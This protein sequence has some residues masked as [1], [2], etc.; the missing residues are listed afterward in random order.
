MLSRR[1]VLS[2]SAGLSCFKNV[3]TEIRKVSSTARQ[4]YADTLILEFGKL[5]K[6][7]CFAAAEPDSS[8]LLLE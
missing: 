1:E 8:K 3:A 5:G 7:V 4:F 2:A 6:I